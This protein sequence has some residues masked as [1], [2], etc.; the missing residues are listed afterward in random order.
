MASAAKALVIEH[1]ER[2]R[3]QRF[4]SRVTL[5]VCGTSQGNGPFKEEN[6]HQDSRDAPSE[7][8]AETRVSFGHR[9]SPVRYP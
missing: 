2:R 9:A 8:D 7:S 5:M 4:P 6:Q 1:R 3:S